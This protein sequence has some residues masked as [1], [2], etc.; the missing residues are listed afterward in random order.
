MLLGQVTMLSGQEQGPQLRRP[1]PAQD[2][3]SGCLG[4]LSPEQQL[5]GCSPVLGQLGLP[6]LGTVSSQTEE[7]LTLKTERCPL[8]LGVPNTTPRPTPG[9]RAMPA[10]P[11]R[12]QPRSAGPSG[13]GATMHWAPL[14][15]AQQVA[16]S[17]SSTAVLGAQE[18]LV[19]IPGWSPP[20]T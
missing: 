7:A 18:D 11:Q 8:P 13:A 6:G 12:T 9:P 10:L 4:L 16:P 17:P 3:V 14:D 2:H 5:R 20:S 15:Q 19:P 1:Q